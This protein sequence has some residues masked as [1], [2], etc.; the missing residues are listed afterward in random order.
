MSKQGEIGKIQYKG[1]PVNKFIF[2]NSL[3]LHPAQEKII[4]VCEALRRIHI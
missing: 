1:D 4:E 2:E 3:R